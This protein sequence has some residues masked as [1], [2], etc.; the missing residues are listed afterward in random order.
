MDWDFSFHPLIVHF[1]VALFISA[2]GVEA[3]SLFFKNDTW[4]QTALHL[5]VLAALTTPFAVLT[6]LYEVDRFQL[7]H[8]VLNLHKNFGLLTMGVSLASLAILWFV[9]KK[10]PANF[11]AVFIIVLLLA[12]GFV[13]LAG[14]NGGRLVYEYGV[15]VADD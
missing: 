12:V 15:G 9:S 7:K 1:P 5:Y 3:L 10:N 8:H 13:S 6:G 14:F 4:H 2:L 11:R